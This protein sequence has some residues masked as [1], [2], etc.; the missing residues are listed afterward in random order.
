MLAADER[1]AD[2]RRAD[3][4][5]AAV[6]GGARAHVGSGAALVRRASVGVGALTVRGAAVGDGDMTASRGVVAAVG[7]AGVAVVAIERR[8]WNAVS[9]RT[10][11]DSIACGCVGTAGPVEDCRVHAAGRRLA[12]VERA[13]LPVVAVDRTRL[14]RVADAA[15]V[16]GAAV[17]VQAITVRDAASRHGR[18]GTTRLG[19]ACIRGTDVGVVAVGWVPRGALSRLAGLEPGAE[20]EG[21]ARLAVGHRRESAPRRGIAVVARARVAVVTGQG[22]ARDRKSTR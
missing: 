2:V 11:L 13:G 14:A 18:V 15:F 8:A 21:S 10:G 16:G 17:A 6:E 5:V 4:A 7:G 22:V 19:I 1:I 9:A 20:V 12:A 3:V